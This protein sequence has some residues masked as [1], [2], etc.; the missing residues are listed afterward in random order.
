MAEFD[1]FILFAAE[2]TDLAAAEADYETVKQLYYELD[3]VDTFDAAIV[4]KKDDGKVKIVKKHEQPTRTGAWVGGGLG[5]AAGAVIALFPAAAIGGGLL[6]GTTAGGAALGALAGHAAGGL[7]R[8]DL[9]ELGEGLDAGDAGLIVVAAVDIE[10]R[11]DDAIKRSDKII[12]KQMKA[13]RKELE[14]EIKEAE[15]EA[16]D[17]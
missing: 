4:E 1:T 17:S 16:S 7:P 3:L 5:L 8:H 11:I 9:K 6:A 12:K 14:K 13:D 15:K 2:Y 10:G